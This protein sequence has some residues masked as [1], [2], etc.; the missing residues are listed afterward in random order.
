MSASDS[1][2]TRKSTRK[3]TVQDLSDHWKLGKPD[4]DGSGAFAKDEDLLEDARLTAPIY[5]LGKSVADPGMASCAF[6]PSKKGSLYVRIEYAPSTHG[7]PHLLAPRNSQNSK[8]GS[9]DV[10]VP[11][12]FLLALVKGSVEWDSIEKSLKSL[13]KALE[14][15]PMTRDE[16]DNTGGKAPSD[17][18][19]SDADEEVDDDDDEEEVRFTE[20]WSSFWSFPT[21]LRFLKSLQRSGTACYVPV[22]KADG[23]LEFRTWSMSGENRHY[24]TWEKAEEYRKKWWALLERTWKIRALSSTGRP[25]RWARVDLKDGGIH[26]YP[27]I[28]KRSFG[29]QRNA[30]NAAVIKEFVERVNE[31]KTLE[32]QVLAENKAQ[33]DEKGVAPCVWEA[34]F[35]DKKDHPSK[36]GYIKISTDPFGIYSTWIT[37]KDWSNYMGVLAEDC[38]GGLKNDVSR[39]PFSLEL[40]QQQSDGPATTPIEKVQKKYNTLLNRAKSIKNTTAATEA[41]ATQAEKIKALS[42]DM[43]IKENWEPLDFGGSKLT[44]TITYKKMAQI[45]GKKRD[46][47]QNAAMGNVQA[48]E[49]AHTLGWKS[50]AKPND[51][52]KKTGGPSSG[53]KKTLPADTAAPKAN[54]ESEES[55][56]FDVLKSKFYPA[57]WLHL[58]AFSW[59][60]YLTEPE[61]PDEDNLGKILKLNQVITLQNPFN[62]VLGTSE[63]NSFMLRYEKAW[64]NLIKAEHRYQREKLKKAKKDIDIKGT[65]QIW[66]N[67]TADDN[68]WTLNTQAAT[69]GQLKQDFTKVELDIHSG[70][71]NFDIKPILLSANNDSEAE[72]LRD[73]VTKFPFL[74]LSVAY[75]VTLTTKSL[76]FNEE[77]LSCAVKFYPFR[78]PFYHHAESMMDRL[79]MKKLKGEKIEELKPLKASD[80]QLDD[81]GAQGGG[82]PG[83]QKPFGGSGQGG[84]SQRGF[85]QGGPPQQRSQQGF[86]QG[87]SSQLGFGQGFQQV[88]PFQQGFG[89]GGP[90][91]Q[92]LGQ[93]HQQFLQN[94]LYGN[95]SYSNPHYF[96]PNRLGA[97]PQSGSYNTTQQ[98]QHMNQPP[99][100]MGN[101]MGYQGTAGPPYSIYDQRHQQY[102]MG[103]G[104]P[105][106]Q[107]PVSQPLLGGGQQTSYQPQAPVDQQQQAAQL[108]S[109]NMELLKDLDDTAGSKV[110]GAKSK[111]KKE[112]RN[113]PKKADKPTGSRE[114]QQANATDLDNLKD[115]SKKDRADWL[116]RIHQGSKKILHDITQ[117]NKLYLDELSGK[118]G[119]S[120]DPELQDDADVERMAEAEKHYKKD[121]L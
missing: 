50:K 70:Q 106:N 45:A 14:L 75:K 65:L 15:Q 81:P 32:D 69:H 57:E 24:S 29:Q 111:S 60:G 101:P 78:R 95:P 109:F 64:Q 83:Q 118:S 9:V 73:I 80:S 112:T 61:I 72:R 113:D 102:M 36:C 7:E 55:G 46:P 26:I 38:E 39:N 96:D 5:R 51:T 115:M 59:G 84:G 120:V 41:F 48:N 121:N 37:G 11:I 30:V 82:N 43:M 47:V 4:E 92:G 108:K 27:E 98:T 86:G 16:D 1:T 67:P 49:L 10:Y 91:Q 2:A 104:M 6:A 34:H 107:P 77:K 20:S 119:Q 79:L 23:K 3:N 97:H 28:E 88:G 74:A 56:P 42:R 53:N 18:D 13:E 44:S 117:G 8:A 93:G 114:I 31:E 62:L 63:T 12:A 68:E 100:Y 76:I 103:M 35:W 87:G 105:P 21:K 71:G 54:P 17:G 19:G 89:Q 33:A 110:S 52:A 90:S 40:T 58:Q 85:G 99:Q 116:S 94:Q 22:R 66:V 25:P